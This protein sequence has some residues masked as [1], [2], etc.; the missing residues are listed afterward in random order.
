MH[1]SR[2]RALTKAEQRNAPVDCA[3]AIYGVRDTTTSSGT[4]AQ[5]SALMRLVFDM[6]MKTVRQ[7]IT[8]ALEG[9]IGFWNELLERE[10]DLSKLQKMTTAVLRSAN[11]AEKIFTKLLAINGQSLS[12]LRLLIQ[13]NIH[14]RNDIGKV[15][16]AQCVVDQLF[17][18][19]T[20]KHTTQRYI[21]G[22]CINS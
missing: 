21:A 16:L 11:D 2:R 3:F 17:H 10:P 1:R 22:N 8:V 12:A 4:D 6:H 5:N 18:T 7:H 13:F 9:Q 19:R 15:R 20:G 14:L